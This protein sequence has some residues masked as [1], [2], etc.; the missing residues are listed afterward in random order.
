MYAIASAFILIWCP[1]LRI[2]VP[3]APLGHLTV[4]GNY[5]R[6]GDVEKPMF[7]NSTF[8]LHSRYPSGAEGTGFS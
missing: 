5:V 7:S 4:L 6:L 2:P 1:R 3:S 8:V